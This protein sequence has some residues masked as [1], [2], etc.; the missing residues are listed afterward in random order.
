MVSNLVLDDIWDAL[1]KLVDPQVRQ[2][3]GVHKDNS[4]VLPNIQNSPYHVSG[5]KSVA[6]ICQE[7]DL[8]ERING[9]Q[10]RHRVSTI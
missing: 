7:A 10:M 9:T 5:W 4:Y 2:I 6:N 8:K 3:A 1:Q